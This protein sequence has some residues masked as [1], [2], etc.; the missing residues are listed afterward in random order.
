MELTLFNSASDKSAHKKR[1]RKIL[2]SRG[3]QQRCK[4]LLAQNPAGSSRRLG[5]HTAAA[6]TAT[7]APR[8]T[9]TATSA[10][11]TVSHPAHTLRLLR[12]LELGQLQQ[13][14]QTLRATRLNVPESANSRHAE[15][16]PY[17]NLVRR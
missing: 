16:P 11:E 5:R 8:T 9:A 6:S 3:L 4:V 1:P 14:F 13:L 12:L 10:A 17:H 2:L 15:N 7:A